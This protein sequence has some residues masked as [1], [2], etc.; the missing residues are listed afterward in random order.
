MSDTIQRM[1]TADVQAISSTDGFRPTAVRAQEPGVQS[2][3]RLIAYPGVADGKATTGVWRGDA[4]TYL[5][6]G[7]ANGEVYIVQTGRATLHIEGEP[8]RA[9]GP[10]D[11]VIL[12]PSLRSIFVVTG[13]LTKFWVKVEAAS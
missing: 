4:G 6:P 9:I 10:G 2:H 7:S 12:P 11:I 5:S 8:Q 3:V 1:P 13:T